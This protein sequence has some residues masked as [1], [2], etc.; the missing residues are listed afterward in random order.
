MAITNDINEPVLL[1]KTLNKLF[2]SEFFLSIPE[3][4]RAYEWE[5]YHVKSLLEDTISGYKKDKPYLMGTII[6]HKNGVPVILI[7]MISL[8]VSSDLL[9]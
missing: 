1:T 6:L 8:M 5:S 4:Q 2:D 7:S 9:H 3:Y